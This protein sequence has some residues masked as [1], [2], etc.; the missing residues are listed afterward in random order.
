MGLEFFA[1][2]SAETEP[3]DPLYTAPEV[4]YTCDLLGGE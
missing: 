2:R 1:G 4:L 3:T